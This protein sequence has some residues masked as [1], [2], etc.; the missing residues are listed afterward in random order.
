MALLLPQPASVVRRQ[1]GDPL[2]LTEEAQ[3]EG[4]K[5]DKAQAAL[6]EYQASPF[7]EST[8]PWLREVFKQLSDTPLPDDENDWPVWLAADLAVPTQIVAHW[9]TNPK[10]SGATSG[11]TPEHMAHPPR[12][13]RTGDGG[14]S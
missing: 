11:Y 12:W 3:K 14:R 4:P 7:Y 9:R 6:R 13:H 8:I 1:P 5:Q 2:R 10:A